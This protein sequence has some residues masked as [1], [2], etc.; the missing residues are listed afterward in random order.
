MAAPKKVSDKIIR[1]TFE[2][3]GAIRE[4]ARRIGLQYSAVYER[5][6]KMG[7]IRNPYS[8]T[9]KQIAPRR[10]I[11]E[12]TVLVIPDIQAPGHHPDALPFLCAVRER[13]SPN[14]IVGIGDEVDFYSLSD[15]AKIPEADAPEHEFEAAR[16]FIRALGAEFPDIVACTSNH[17]HGRLEKAR[18]RARLPAWMLKDLDEI[19]DAPPGWSWHS[20]IRMGDIL[21]EHGHKTGQGLKRVVT[22]E[23][24][25]KYG[26]FYSI[27]IGHYHSKMGQFTPD[28]KVGDKFFWGAFTGCLVDPSHPFFGYSMG[29]ERLGTVVIRD[30]RC[31]PIAMPLDSEGRWTGEI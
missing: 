28:I 6:Q 12:G 4:T 22:E 29:N 16:N 1:E 14:N 9:K 8:N 25:A 26:R 2:L 15:Y 10:T 24:P 21:F 27:V 17:V 13:Y 20:Q 7:L 30:G 3:T 31:I 19:L 18:A 11:P 5:L 23:I